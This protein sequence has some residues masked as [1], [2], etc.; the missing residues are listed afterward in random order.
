MVLEISIS[1]SQRGAI[2]LTPEICVDGYDPACRTRVVTHIHSDHLLDLEKSVLTARRLIATPITMDLLEV[3]GY[4]IPPHKRIALDYGK[5]LALDGS[6]LK[7]E[8]AHHIAGTAQV[9]IETPNLIAAYTSDFKHPRSRTPV[10][11]GVDVL[12]IDATYGDPR[13]RRQDETLILENFAKLLYRLLA[14]KPVHVYAYYGKAQEVMMLLREYG[15]DAP[16][17]ASPRQWRVLNVLSRYG[18]RVSDVYLDGTADANEIRE[19]G[20]YVA[21]HHHTKFYSLRNVRSV[22]HV[23]LS[24]WLFSTPIRRLNGNSWI[25][26]FSDHADFDELIAYVDEARPRLVIVDGFRGGIAA[27]R[28]ANHVEKEL[29]IRSLVKP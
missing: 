15:I 26:G 1:I 23:L 21:F 16:F 25:V 13:Y 17:I 10:L 4:T 28:F 6:E 12:V 11:K 9:V 5:A 22:H 20:W 3:L 29:G 18:F 2:L 24:G 19:S 8:Y 7:L 14:E 27:H